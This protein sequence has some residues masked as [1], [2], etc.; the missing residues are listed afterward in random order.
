[1]FRYMHLVFCALIVLATPA[2]AKELVFA[3]DTSFPPMES[4]GPDDAIVGFGPDVI[5]AAGKAAGFTPVFRNTPWDDLFTGLENRQFDAV[6]AS[7]TITP[8]R[9]KRMDFSTP[10]FESYQA[11]IVKNTSAATSL[12]DLAWKK[13]GAH[14]TSTSY[15][16]CKEIAR[17]HDAFAKAYPHPTAAIA[18]LESGELDAVVIDAPAAF[19]FA[20]DHEKYSQTMKLGFLIP[21]ADPEPFGIAVRKGDKE[22]LELINKGI[23]AIKASGEYQKI[24]DKW[25]AHVPAKPGSNSFF[26][27]PWTSG[28]SSLV[29]AQK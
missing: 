10:Y 8:D 7:V 23:A 21:S 4:M 15:D 17:L 1:M 25:L 28:P 9:E 29:L 18:A 3:V 22:A 6:L 12:K 26:R 24:Y 5:L 19:G 14:G 20:L 27:L 2:Q 11:V 13:V 16:A